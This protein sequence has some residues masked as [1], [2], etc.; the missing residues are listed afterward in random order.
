[1]RDECY[2]CKRETLHGGKCNG[3]DGSVPCLAY[4]KDSRGHRVYV[5]NM[6]FEVPIWLD[7]P[8]EDK[9]CDY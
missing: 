8:E 3:K 6:R 4:E 1:M 2:T 7:I 9:P 5:R